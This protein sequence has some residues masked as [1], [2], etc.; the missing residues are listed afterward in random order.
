M[1]RHLKTDHAVSQIDEN[2]GKNETKI[3]I[4]VNGKKKVMS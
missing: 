4:Q 3:V 2:L 1:F